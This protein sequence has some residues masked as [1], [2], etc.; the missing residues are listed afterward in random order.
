[1][2]SP[3]LIVLMPRLYPPPP[4]SCLPLRLRTSMPL[5]LTAPRLCGSV[6]RLPWRHPDGR[7][8]G[9]C[10][11]GSTTSSAPPDSLPN[12]SSSASTPSPSTIKLSPRTLVQRTPIVCRPSSGEAVHVAVRQRQC[13]P[14]RRNAMSPQRSE[15][16]EGR[17]SRQHRLLAPA[18]AAPSASRQQLRGDVGL[19][20]A[21]HA[22][23]P[24]SAL[25]RRAP[26]LH[27]EGLQGSLEAVQRERC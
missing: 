8:T 7:S 13:T 27:A 15:D 23:Q 20:K 14:P 16:W 25:L 11:G 1:M 22:P 9:K 2:V 5:S 4:T 26:T 21:P 12:G 17:A 18:A 10:A 3:V 6:C 19:R 24:L